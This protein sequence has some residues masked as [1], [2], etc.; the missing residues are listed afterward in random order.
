MP[1]KMSGKTDWSSVLWVL[2]M[3]KYHCLY[4]VLRFSRIAPFWYEN[5]PIYEPF[6]IPTTSYLSDNNQLMKVTQAREVT[7]NWMATLSRFELLTFNKYENFNPPQHWMPIM[8]VV[9]ASERCGRNGV[10]SFMALRRP[11]P[12]SL[13]KGA[14]TVSYEAF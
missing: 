9:F 6:L 2:Y 10:A 8:L 13:H 4:L 1:A 11:L 5:F 14:S 3:S 7:P 12:E